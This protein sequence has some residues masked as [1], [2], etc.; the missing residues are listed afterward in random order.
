MVFF[1]TI[2]SVVILISHNGM[3]SGVNR[4]S[5]CIVRKCE[6]MEAIENKLDIGLDR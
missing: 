6:V 4:H 5:E 3:C 1:E 2:Y